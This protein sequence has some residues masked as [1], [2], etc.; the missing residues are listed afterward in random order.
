VTLLDLRTEAAAEKL[1]LDGSMLSELDRTAAIGTWRG[2][3]V[4]EHISA[5]VFA[6]MIP[7]MMAAGVPAS[8]IALV[9]DMIAEELRH[10]V[11]CAAVVHALG[12]DATAELP[13]LPA[14]PLHA[15][16][17]PLEALL[18][19]VLSIACLSETVAVAL[20]GAERELAG[21]PAM[22]ETLRTILADEVGH[23]RFGWRLLETL[24]SRLTPELRA[25]LGDYL[26]AAFRHLR[27]HELAHLPPNPPPSA[28]AEEYGVCD[29][30]DARALFFATVRDVIIPGLE[31]HGLAAERAWIT[32][33]AA[34]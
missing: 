31:A 19:N 24:A 30:N 9:A 18:R 14:V 20:I 2:R 25:R 4:N 26:V 5:R 15:D 7:Q 11:Q 6:G 10:G 12:G 3:M 29:G 13:P 21:P 28:L 17:E 22:Q 27:E 33:G 16:A 32:S 8:S 1:A 34:S 23:A